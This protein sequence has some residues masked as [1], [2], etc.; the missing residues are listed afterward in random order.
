MTINEIRLLTQDNSDRAL[1]L[2]TLS[3]VAEPFSLTTEPNFSADQRTRISLFVQDL[4]V[5]QSFPTIV[6]KA[7][8]AH[9]N[10]FE[11]PFEILGVSSFFPFQQLVVRLPENLSTGELIITV[12]VNGSVTNVG[13]ISIKP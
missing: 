1:A 10:R 5:F 8:D 7:V 6:V 4:R 9:Q 3:K 2:N 12:T 13:R 11:L